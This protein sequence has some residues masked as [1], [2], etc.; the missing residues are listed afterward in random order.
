MLVEN[1]ADVH[2][3]DVDGDTPIHWAAN[4]G[5]KDMV[6]LLLE[7]GADINALNDAHQTALHIAAIR[8]NKDLFKYLLESGADFEIKTAKGIPALI[9]QQQPDRRN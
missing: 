9:W 1:G 2:R 6:Q 8:K 3:A 5:Y 4:H 7:L